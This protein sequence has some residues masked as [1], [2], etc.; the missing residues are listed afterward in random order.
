V[1]RKLRLE[2][3][4]PIRKVAARVD[5]DQSTMGK[6]ERGERLPKE[7]LLPKLAKFFDMELDELTKIYNCQ[8]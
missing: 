2:R 7:E 4:L 5:V 3:G 1:L 8:F 6:F